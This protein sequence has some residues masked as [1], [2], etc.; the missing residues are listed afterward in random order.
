MRNWM[1]SQYHNSL[2]LSSSGASARHFL[3]GQLGSLNRVPLKKFDGPAWQINHRD[4]HCE[5]KVVR[6]AGLP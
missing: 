6:L 5:I 2:E 3:I 1:L 4:L